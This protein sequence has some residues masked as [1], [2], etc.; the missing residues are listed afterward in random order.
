MWDVVA[1]AMKV[2]LASLIWRC[3]YF[4]SLLALCQQTDSLMQ[5]VLVHLL[6]LLLYHGSCGASG[7]R[8]LPKHCNR[9]THTEWLNEGGVPLK[10]ALDDTIVTFVTDCVMLRT[11]I[12]H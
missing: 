11:V 5:V 4:A 12:P 8:V 1:N 7:S 2:L 9:H 6:H 3:V 10:E